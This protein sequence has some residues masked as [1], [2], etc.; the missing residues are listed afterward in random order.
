MASFANSME[1]PK[2]IA[3]DIT[4]I[5]GRTPMV[6][7]GRIAREEACF[8]NIV[9]KMESM[10]PASSVKDRIG[11]H[12]I[13]CAKARGDIRPG[14]TT[15]VEPTSGNTGQIYPHCTFITSL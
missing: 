8:G 1:N 2:K 4:D 3:D 11:K 5:I 15:L 6:R 12:M 9:L 13:E 14:F 10:E 7:L